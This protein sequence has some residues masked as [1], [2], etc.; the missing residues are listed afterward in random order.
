MKLNNMEI[1]DLKQ[2]K[3]RVV[4][5]KP[6]AIASEA[7]AVGVVSQVGDVIHL[8]NIESPL[9]FDALRC[10]QGEAEVGNVIFSLKFLKQQLKRGYSDIEEID[11]TVSN[12][13]LGN[14][15]QFVSEDHLSYARN[16]LRL[17]SCLLQERTCKT[18]K[19]TLTQNDASKI[20]FDK[21]SQFDVIT[22]TKLF[23]GYSL[24]VSRGKKIKFPIYGERIIAAPVSMVTK[25]INVAKN[26]AEAYCA[27][28]SVARNYVK[29]NAVI[30]VILPSIDKTSNLSLLEDS[31]GELEF[32]ADANGVSVRAE[33]NIDE[34]A[35]AVLH[36]ER[37][38]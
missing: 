37:S 34:L 21:I 1:P 23:E 16:Y 4:Y 5:L 35:Q 7:I 27:K 18:A 9:E 30:Y 2:G 28:L 14:S 6:S 38:S 19:R 26:I 3:M 22:A 31:L 11:S 32:I 10:L 36:D 17:S 12:C 24:D 13:F 15:Q 33:K 8:T 29:R 25:Q 20:L